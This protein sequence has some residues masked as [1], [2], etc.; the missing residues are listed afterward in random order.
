MRVSLR[1]PWILALLSLALAGCLT[2]PGDVDRQ[3]QAATGSGASFE[4]AG[5]QTPLPKACRTQSLVP[6]PQLDD[7]A[8]HSIVNVSP[9]YEATEEIEPGVFRWDLFGNLEEVWLLHE[10]DRVHEVQLD[11]TVAFSY[12]DSPTE[13]H[14][15]HYSVQVPWT[16]GGSGWEVIDIPH[17]YD[18]ALCYLNCQVTHY[19]DGESVCRIR[20]TYRGPQFGP[21]QPMVP[22]IEDVPSYDLN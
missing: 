14:Q 11:V 18:R 13:L 4:P 2:E 22:A 6:D 10:E 15:G 19:E 17:R 20:R 3:G 16:P 7:L 8:R 9:I 5:L 12:V 21:S 1:S